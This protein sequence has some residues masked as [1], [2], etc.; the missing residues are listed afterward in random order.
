MSISSLDEHTI[1]PTIDP[2]IDLPEEYTRAAT[3]T[4]TETS[5]SPS[6][7]AASNPD[8]K[9][10]KTV[11]RH[12]YELSRQRWCRER[13]INRNYYP[14]SDVLDRVEFSHSVLRSKGRSVLGITTPLMEAIRAQLPANIR[15]LLQAGANP[16]GVPYDLLD[17]YAALFLRFRPC[18]R[19]LFDGSPDLASRY[20]FLTHM[21]LPQISSLTCEEV[22]DRFEDGMA[23]FWCEEGFTQAFFW[24]NGESMHS[25][26][27]AAKCGSI[28]IFEMLL[29]AGADASF[30]T[31]PQFC[32]PEPATESS[33]C[34]SSPLHAAIEA[35]NGRMVEY[36]LEK[37]FDPNTMP[38]VNPTRCVTP[39]MS[40]IVHCSSFNKEAFDILS[41][42]PN[43][44]FEIRTPVY[45]VHL[46][47]FAVARLDLELL[48]HVVKKTPLTNAGETALGHTLLHIACMPADA[49]QVQR[50][51]DIT[52]R[53]IHETRD[54]RPFNDTNALRARSHFSDDEKHF[55]AQTEVVKYLWQN[56]I[57]DLDKRDVHGNTALHY[58]AG[59]RAVNQDLLDWWFN[60]GGSNVAD[61][62]HDSYN[63]HGTTPW[64]MEAVGKEVRTTRADALESQL[65]KYYSDERAKKKEEIWRDLL[66]M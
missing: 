27:E 15:I 56:G 34:V 46:L 36:L 55:A 41:Q 59:C 4:A 37:G 10:L 2:V 16:N 32:V 39:L 3:A 63:E 6:M 48:K 62:W 53:S 19:R 1:D 5:L 50:Y 42:A 43:I 45:G 17:D 35:R 12:G 61:H 14:T 20:V 18:I 65:E 33:L 58:L 28:E 23:P 25:L 57:T 24:T 22:E 40:T 38:L 11:L 9:I 30:W 7:K 21:N 49:S 64:Q 60:M 31:Q 44:N 47:H 66:Q 52:C 29:S 8:F 26:I 51:A 54:L 13:D